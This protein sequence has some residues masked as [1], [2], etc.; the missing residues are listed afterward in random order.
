MGWQTRTTPIVKTE[1]GGIEAHPPDAGAWKPIG[2]HAGHVVWRVR[3]YDV[4]DTRTDKGMIEVL[5]GVLHE[6]FRERAELVTVIQEMRK[7]HADALRELRA[8]LLAA[9]E[10]AQLEVKR[11]Y[12]RGYDAGR[13]KK[14]AVSS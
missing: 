12:A 9:R 4:N 11:S 14:G 10:A 1:D 5:D 3:L 13:R 2:T 6:S 7:I 8:R